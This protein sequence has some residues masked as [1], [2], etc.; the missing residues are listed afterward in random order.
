MTMTMKKKL[1]YQR[2][3]RRRKRRIGRRANERSLRGSRVD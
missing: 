3:R 2:R 1:T